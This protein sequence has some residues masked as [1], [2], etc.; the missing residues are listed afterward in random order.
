MI[1]V[2]WFYCSVLIFES[3]SHNSEEVT[4]KWMDEAVTLMRPIQLPD[5]D[6]VLFRANNETMLYPNGYWDQLQVECL[7]HWQKCKF[8]NITISRY[9]FWI[10]LSI[11]WGDAF[12]KLWHL[13][14]RC[15]KKKPLANIRECTSN[16]S[17]DLHRFEQMSKTFLRLL[18]GPVRGSVLKVVPHHDQLRSGI[19]SLKEVQSL[20]MSSLHIVA[21]K[22]T[23]M[24]ISTHIVLM[25]V[26]LR[27]S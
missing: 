16:Y 23:R 6:L 27:S 25:T 10:Y 5:F 20:V 1:Y 22:E 14:T 3:Y 12:C 26:F 18:Y 11:F 7:L 13:E 17:N 21:L 9:N 19:H 8:W 24:L 2:E 4:L 15:T